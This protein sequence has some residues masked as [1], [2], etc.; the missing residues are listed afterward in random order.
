[1]AEQLQLAWDDECQPWFID[2]DTGRPT[3]TFTA[4]VVEYATP[5]EIQ[6]LAA[7]QSR[8]RA[9]FPPSHE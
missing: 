5:E 6:G 8:A 1:M 4:A 3:V 9:G 2:P 7:R